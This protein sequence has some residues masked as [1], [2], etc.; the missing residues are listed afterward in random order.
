MSGITA[1]RATAVAAALVSLCGVGMAAAAAFERAA[2]PVDRALVLAVAVTITLAAHV[3]PA[4][5]R[6]TGGKG[7]AVGSIWGLWLACMGITIYGHATFFSGAAAHAGSAR[8]SAVQTSTHTAALTDQ[9]ANISARPLGMV[10]IDLAA[11]HARAAALNLQLTR[12][13]Q[14]QPGRCGARRLAVQQ[15]Q[16][17]TDA[18]KTE[19]TEAQRAADLRE[20]LAASAAALDTRRAAAAVD[21]VAGQL[22]RL[23]GANVEALTLLVAVLSAVVV[24]LL[25]A[26]L[27]SE[28]LRAPQPDA[29]TAALR[30]FADDQ[31]KRIAAARTATTPPRSQP[32]I[33]AGRVRPQSTAPPPRA[34]TPSTPAPHSPPGDRHGSR[35]T[36]L[37]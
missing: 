2:T 3:L 17:R 34:A 37:A 31:E 12:C 10:A 18:L 8:A 19:H 27:W 13:E 16:A 30:L 24:E 5:A 32:V 4:L 20:Q 9:L 21:P 35:I 36:A 15:A 1:R 33:P 6:R 22:A 25:A 23:T 11:A 26:V 28:A 7:P 29:A 14:D